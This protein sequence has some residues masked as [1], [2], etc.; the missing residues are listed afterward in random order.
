MSSLDLRCATASRFNF[1][2]EVAEAIGQFR[3]IYGGGKLLRLEQTA[4]LQGPRLSV[5]A[6]GDIEDDGV[7]VELRRGVAVHGAGG[8]ML[9]LRSDE[10]AGGFGGVVAADAGLR[11]PFQLAQSDVHRF[12]VRVPHP[13]I[14]TDQRGE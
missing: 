14:P 5:V 4:L 13:V 12:P 3:L 7:G 11:V 6:H 8:V 10:L 1:V 2:A 9:E